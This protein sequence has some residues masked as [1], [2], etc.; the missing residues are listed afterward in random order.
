MLA[1]KINTIAT[2]YRVKVASIS[3]KVNN[4]NILGPLI[5][6][7]PPENRYSSLIGVVS[8]GSK[9]CGDPEKPGVYAR[10]TYVLPWIKK[11]IKGT[12]CRPPDQ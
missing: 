6:L 7:E 1:F 12:T 9:Y 8:W 11:N 5:T 3:E 2:Y 4:R 10:V